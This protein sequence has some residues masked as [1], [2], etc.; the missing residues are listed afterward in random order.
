MTKEKYDLEKV[1]K[2]QAIIRGYLTRK[3]NRK[4]KDDFTLD[5]LKK[6]LNTYIKYNKILSKQNKKLSK[7]KIRMPNFPSEISENIVKF[8]ILKTKNICPTWYTKSGDLCLLDKKI[9]VKGFR[10]SGPTSFGPTEKWDIL[11]FI[12]CTNYINKKFKIYEIMLSN[13]DKRWK[14]IKVN[15]EETL[16]D[17]SKQKRR[18]RLKFQSIKEQLG[19]HCKL[20]FNGSIDQ[21]S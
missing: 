21:L 2:C 9:E 6:Y 3:N 8:I 13:K 18:P 14:N 15:K 1:I 4:L 12:D 7:K 20:I 11:Y 10:S 5:I 17:Q 19:K 16:K